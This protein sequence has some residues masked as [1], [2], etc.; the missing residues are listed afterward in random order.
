MCRIWV[1]LSLFA[2]A[3]HALGAEGEKGAA[4]RPNVILIV[5]DTVRFDALSADNTPLL[6]SLGKRGVVFSAAYSTHDFTPTSHFSM[7][8]GLR[9]G[10]GGDEDRLETGLPWQL[11]QNGYSTFATVANGL[12]TPVQLPVLRG[13]GD[14]KAFGDMNR[15]SQIESLSDVTAI[16]ERL[17]RFHVR[18]TRHTRLMLYYSADRL[19]PIFLEQMRNAKPPYFGLVNLI[20]AHEPYVPH[21]SSY[22]PETNLPKGFIGDVMGRP[23]SRELQHPETIT[24]P[25]RRASVEAGIAAVGFPRLLSADLS[26]EALAIYKA[27]YLGAV[28]DLDGVLGQFFAAAGNEHLLDNTIVI[29][30]SDHGE[31]FGEAGHITHMLRDRGDFESTHHVPLIVLLPKS[32]ARRGAAVIDRRV[33]LANLAATIYDIAGLDWSAL[34]SRYDAYPQSLASLFMSAQPRVARVTL[35]TTVPQPNQNQQADREREQALRALGYI[36]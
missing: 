2:I 12:L 24:D 33:S 30:T 6:D 13:F 29:I 9:D 1:A 15:S 10:L 34:A 20:D 4:R 17:S 18:A 11:R 35:P 5:L 28:H 26:P 31:E 14:F 16:E 21:L 25:A 27:R 32:I 8:T 36:N 19:L 3:F 22:Q 23:L 7:M